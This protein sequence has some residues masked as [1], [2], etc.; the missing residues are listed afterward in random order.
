ME[1]PSSWISLECRIRPTIR[2]F[3]SHDHRRLLRQGPLYNQTHL[4][5]RPRVTIVLRCNPLKILCLT[6]HHMRTQSYT[7]KSPLSSVLNR[8]ANRGSS[9]DNIA[10]SSDKAVAYPP[11]H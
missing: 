6:S 10:I 4:A 2:A 5:R 8:Q 7:T 3:M 9:A 11:L 1:T